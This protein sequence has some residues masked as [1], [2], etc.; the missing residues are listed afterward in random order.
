MHLKACSATEIGTP[1]R[2]EISSS[3]THLL[4]FI[5]RMSSTFNIR[6]LFSLSKPSFPV[7]T[8]GSVRHLLLLEVPEPET[9]IG[10]GKV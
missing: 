8:L 3:A 2:H 6:S 7:P 1:H 4:S 10:P 5:T 9:S